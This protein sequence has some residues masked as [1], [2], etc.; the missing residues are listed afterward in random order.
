MNTAGPTLADSAAAPVAAPSLQCLAQ[1]PVLLLLLQLQD[2][3]GREE[4]ARIA[5]E[6]EAEAA[7]A[8]A[9]ASSAAAAAASTSS[10]SS[11]AAAGGASAEA[12]AGFGQ[13][14]LED[15][16]GGFFDMQDTAAGAD[17][18]GEGSAQGGA[19]AAR[20]AVEWSRHDPNTFF[21]VDEDEVEEADAAWFSRR[22]PFD[23]LFGE[24][25]EQLV[26][27]RQQKGKQPRSGG[28]SK[29]G[30]KQGNKPAASQQ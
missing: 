9:T 29:R 11:R 26:Q 19:A 18:G 16:A 5:A 8:G 10:S 3:I 1:R 30:G 12:A 2:A 27:Q 21:A 4:F 14:D 24:A 7:G 6:A 23:D 17:A 28:G 22:G 15:D 20:P 13:E 25:G